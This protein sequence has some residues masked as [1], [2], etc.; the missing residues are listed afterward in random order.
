MSKH[1]IT[2][3]VAAVVALVC[4][5]AQAAWISPTAIADYSKEIAGEP[6]LVPANVID[7]DLATA[8][9]VSDDST[10]NSSPPDYPLGPWTGH[11]VF[12]L[13]TAQV[14]SGLKWWARD[15]TAEIGPSGPVDVYRFLDDDPTNNLGLLDDIE[16]DADIALVGAVTFAELN[17]NASEE[18]DFSDFSGRYVGIRINQAHENTWDGNITFAEIEFDTSPIPEPSTAV[19]LLGLSLFALIRRRR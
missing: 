7:G 3:S 14:V 5:S 2:L 17:S 1:I 15:V 19:L 18:I 11:F 6:Q 10:P 13:G 12:D 9:G 4:V 8:G 16:G